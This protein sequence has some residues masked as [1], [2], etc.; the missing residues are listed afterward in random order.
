MGSFAMGV[1]RFFEK[2]VVVFGNFVVLFGH[3][4]CC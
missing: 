3:N 2:F 4:R 1:E